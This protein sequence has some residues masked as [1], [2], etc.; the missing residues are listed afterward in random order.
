MIAAQTFLNASVYCRGLTGDAAHRSF[1]A[2]NTAYYTI[3]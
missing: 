1:S 2:S 3:S